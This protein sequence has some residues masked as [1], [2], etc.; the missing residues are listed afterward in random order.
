[1][2]RNCVKNVRNS[3]THEENMK[4]DFFTPPPPLYIQ[5]ANNYTAHPYNMVLVPANF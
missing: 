4:W 2:R 5:N 1:M 3:I